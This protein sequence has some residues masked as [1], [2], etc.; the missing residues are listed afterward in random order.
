MLKF[1]CIKYKLQRVSAIINTN[2]WPLNEILT[3]HH[4]Y[5]GTFIDFSYIYRNNKMFF[6]IFFI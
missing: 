1:K 2:I 3:F 4:L 6:F 5:F